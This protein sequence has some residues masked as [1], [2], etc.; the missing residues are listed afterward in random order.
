[1]QQQLLQQK[2]NADGTHA[3]AFPVLSLS[4]SDLDRVL[5]DAGFKRMD[6]PES[7]R[8]LIPREHYELIMNSNPEVKRGIDRGA[9]GFQ[10]KD[11]KQW[12]NPNTGDTTSGVDYDLVQPQV[13]SFNDPFTIIDERIPNTTSRQ[14][15]DIVVNELKRKFA[16]VAISQG[17]NSKRAVR[18]LS[19]F[20]LLKGISAQDAV[21][22]CMAL[23]RVVK[24]EREFAKTETIARQNPVKDTTKKIPSA[25]QSG[26]L[27][28][29][30]PNV[31]MAVDPAINYRIE[32]PRAAQFDQIADANEQVELAMK[33]WERSFEQMNN[34]MESMFKQAF[35]DT[36]RQIRHL[37]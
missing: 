12:V 16:K 17:K 32:I 23:L 11:Y 35:C 20:A 27:R 29:I 33:E 19:E 6:R 2:W 10:L 1:M 14:V 25:N 9:Y 5:L 37:R 36:N 7:K 24:G 22:E 28:Q 3:T 13:Q 34:Q 31:Y 8:G 21:K 26:V 4:M 18:C 30:A 15:L